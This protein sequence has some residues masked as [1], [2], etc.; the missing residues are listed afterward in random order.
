VPNTSGSSGIDARR[1]SVWYPDVRES[2]SRGSVSGNVSRDTILSDL[3]LSA[4]PV[5]KRIRPGPMKWQVMRVPIETST[6]PGQHILHRSIPTNELSYPAFSESRRPALVI[7]LTGMKIGSKEVRCQ[8]QVRREIRASQREPRGPNPVP[9]GDGPW[10]VGFGRKGGA[11][12]RESLESV[13]QRSYPVAPWILRLDS[14]VR[15]SPNYDRG[16]C[17]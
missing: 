9:R 8:D 3:S 14:D 2:S 11:V 17:P 13:C 5:S 15:G 16:I 6:P 4:T 7:A 12:R 1:R 10:L